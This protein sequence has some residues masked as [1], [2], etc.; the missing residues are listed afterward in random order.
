MKIDPDFVAQKRSQGFSWDHVARMIG[1]SVPTLRQAS[2]PSWP[3]DFAYQREPIKASPRRSA[4]YV[5]PP[6]MNIGMGFRMMEFLA[7][8]GPAPTIVLAEAA[9]STTNVASVRLNQLRVEGMVRSFG[10]R[11]RLTWDLTDAGRRRVAES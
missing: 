8:M 3:S 2:D 10:N 1:V 11:K 5:A 7:A 6:E 9:G 4:A